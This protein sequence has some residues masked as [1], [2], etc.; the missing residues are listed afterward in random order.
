MKQQLNKPIAG[1]SNPSRV[2]FFQK[3]TDTAVSTEER[4]PFFDKES[5]PQL[6]AQ[7]ALIQRSPLPEFTGQAIGQYNFQLPRPANEAINGEIIATEELVLSQEAP[8]TFTG[9]SD[10][11]TAQHLARIH[12]QQINAVLRDHEDRYHVFKTNLR[13]FENGINYTLSPLEPNR[14]IQHTQFVNATQSSTQL[15]TAAWVERLQLAIRYRNEGNNEAAIPIFVQLIAQAT[16]TSVADFNIANST[17]EYRPGLNF[18]INMHH[19]YGHGGLFQLPTD[20]STPIQDAILAIGPGVFDR[21]NPND[22]RATFLHELTHYA[23]AQR[24]I[25]LLRIWR[26]SGSRLSF[27]SWLS[28]QE[29]RDR[30]S[31]TERLIT[32]RFTERNDHSTETLAHLNAF[33]YSYPRADLSDP[34]NFLFRSFFSFSGH[35]NT[36][37]RE[38]QDTT[39]QSIL[40]FYNT[41]TAPYQSR[42][43]NYVNTKRRQTMVGHRAIPMNRIINALN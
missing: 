34:D 39:I 8:G 35:W 40:R 26:A 31:A 36:A 37:G 29:R 25:E 15:N 38:L 2:P 32:A 42:F 14:T 23:Q 22:V 4:N 43:F 6:Q 33:L 5:T 10:E 18:N 9:F 19:A 13:P 1:S 12:D 17:S 20:R 7:T 41:L 11:A 3:E 27:E 24:S 21:N 30:I 16:R 28:Q